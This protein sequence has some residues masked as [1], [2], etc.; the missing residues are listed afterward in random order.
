MHLIYV[1]CESTERRLQ[2]C[3]VQLPWRR[4]TNRRWVNG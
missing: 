4:P 1:V 2:S 3:W